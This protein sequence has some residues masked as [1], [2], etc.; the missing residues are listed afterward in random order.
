MT[1]STA[2][3]SWFALKLKLGFVLAMKDIFVLPQLLKADDGCS[4]NSVRILG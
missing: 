1:Y 4:Y 3:P 2:E